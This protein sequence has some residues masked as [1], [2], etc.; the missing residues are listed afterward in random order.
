MDELRNTH[1]AS[2]RT[3]RRDGRPVDTPI[4]FRL[5]GH[6]LVFRTKVGPKSK[7]LTAR[8]DVELRAC[9]WR[10]RVDAKAP[11]VTGRATI[12]SGSEAES[13]NRALHKRYGWHWN[14]VPLLRIPGVTNVHAELSILEKLRWARNRSVWPDSVIVRVD[15][16]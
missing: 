8:P 11:T 1:Y 5:D 13:A 6:V 14:V 9:D 10:G 16:E 12:L 7:R 4:W 3:F 15:L 2:L